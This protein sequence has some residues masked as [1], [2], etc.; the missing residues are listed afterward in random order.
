MTKLIAVLALCLSQMYVLSAQTKPTAKPGATTVRSR[1]ATGKAAPAAKTAKSKP[2]SAAAKLPAKPTTQPQTTTPAAESTTTATTSPAE[3]QPV[4]EARS[5]ARVGASDGTGF[6]KGDVLLSPG[7][8]VGAIG[9]GGGFGY[10]NGSGFLPL[11][12]SLEYSLNVLG[13]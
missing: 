6:A 4:G 5:P 3:S 9:Y 13:L 11:S 7:I 2:T 1:S 12:V 8:S 10:G